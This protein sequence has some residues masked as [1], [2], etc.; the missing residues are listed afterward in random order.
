LV[1]HFLFRCA[2]ALNHFVEVVKMLLKRFD[3][4]IKP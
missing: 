1:A 2:F 3:N 4:Y